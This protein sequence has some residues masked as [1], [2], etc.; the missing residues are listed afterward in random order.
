M[1][2][3]N[4]PSIFVHLLDKTKA[5]KELDKLSL[6]A[7]LLL[8]WNRLC[9]PAVSTMF[10]PQPDPILLNWLVLDNTIEHILLHS[11]ELVSLTGMD[12]DPQKKEKLNIQWCTALVT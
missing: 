10:P 4:S 1:Q 6:A 7:I 11:N 9:S 12:L 8:P 5:S 2:D 3:I